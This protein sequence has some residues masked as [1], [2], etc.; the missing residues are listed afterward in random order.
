M[1][2]TEDRDLLCRHIEAVWG[3]S[4]PPLVGR[5]VDLEPGSVMPP[6]SLYLAHFAVGE[7]GVWRPNVLS[8]HRVALLRRGH[9][10]R[11]VFDRAIGFRK[12]VVLRAPADLPAMPEAAARPLISADEALIEAFEARSASYFLDP[13]RGPCFGVIAAGR[14]VSVAHSSRRTAAACELGI[15]TLANARRQGHARA[16]TLAWT[17][18]IRDE[19]LEPIYSASADNG[20][21]LA[22][23]A[24][25]GYAV[26]IDGSYGPMTSARD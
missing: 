6:W 11:A 25:C 12:E 9:E 13:Q 14:L 2:E 24:A 23:A 16:A 5:S 17:R 15:N 19:G 10:A 8:D 26:V 3:I 21:S 4:V 22:L 18:A 20:A 1:S 7:V